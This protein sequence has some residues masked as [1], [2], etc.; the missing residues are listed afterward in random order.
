MNQIF[1]RFIYVFFFMF[2]LPCVAYAESKII[3]A[4][5]IMNFDYVETDVDGSFLDGEKGDIPGIFFGFETK[6]TEL[7]TFGIAF[8]R[9]KGEV[10]YEGHIQTNPLDLRYEGLP[11][12]TKTDQNITSLIASLSYSLA[13]HRPLSI[14]GTF[15]IKRWER[16]IQSTFISGIDNFG[17]PYQDL[18]VSGLYEIYEWWQLTFGLHYNLKLTAKS[19]MDFYGG[20]LRT[21]D[22][23]MKVFSITFNLEEK[24]GYEAGLAW[25]YKLSREHS[26]GLAMD[27]TFW[28]FGRSNVIFNSVE[29][30]SESNMLEFKLVYE[31]SFDHH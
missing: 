17:D 1:N 18:F 20:F 24:W 29:P 13:Q 31:Y 16:D 26:L 7:L 10:D 28:E 30:D 14:Y 15:T 9:Y 2:V 3:I 22:P 5:G 6:S 21:L 11:L 27:Y 23:T 19:Y 4:P 8:E 25:M 12:S